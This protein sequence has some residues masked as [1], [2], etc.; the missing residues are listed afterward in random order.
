[1]HYAV[2]IVHCT[3]KITIIQY[4]YKLLFI[5][6]GINNANISQINYVHLISHSVLISMFLTVTRW[7]SLNLCDKHVI[8]YYAKH[9]PKVLNNGPNHLW[10]FILLL[11]M[12]LQISLANSSSVFK[13]IHLEKGLHIITV[14]LV[15]Y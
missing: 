4:I 14:F 10:H 2:M 7:L 1:M 9:S 15:Y 5:T 6:Y 13:R 11:S 12:M 8:M 3:N